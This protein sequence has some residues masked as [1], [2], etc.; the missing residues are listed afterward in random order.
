MNKNN[1]SIQNNLGQN[2][3]EWVSKYIQNNIKY[4]KIY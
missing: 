3:Q 4:I 2:T 1:Q